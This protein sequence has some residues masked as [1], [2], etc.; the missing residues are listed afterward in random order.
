MASTSVRAGIVAALLVFCS[1]LVTPAASAQPTNVSVACTSSSG[2]YFCWVNY[3]G[4]QN[5]T[6]IRW[7]SNGTH[8]SAFDN[9]TF[10]LQTC[11]LSAFYTVRAVVTDVQG[12]AEDSY[13]FTCRLL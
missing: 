8:I 2:Q 12:S 7:Y 1:A 5:P 4:A 13:S 6:T 3:S 9:R 11:T 10:L